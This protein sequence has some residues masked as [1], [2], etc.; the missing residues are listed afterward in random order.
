MGSWVLGNKLQALADDLTVRASFACGIASAQR[1][2]SSWQHLRIEQ[3]SPFALSNI[4]VV[5]IDLLP[6]FLE[7]C[8]I[9]DFTPVVDKKR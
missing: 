6:D 9:F 5:H 7:P 3:S 2:L 4:L 8:S 1:P